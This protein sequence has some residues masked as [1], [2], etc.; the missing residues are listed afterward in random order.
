MVW[1]RAASG[2]PVTYHATYGGVPT[3]EAQFSFKI[4]PFAYPFTR[5]RETKTS[6]YWPGT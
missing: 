4:N 5:N 6:I 2:S 1:A 3:G